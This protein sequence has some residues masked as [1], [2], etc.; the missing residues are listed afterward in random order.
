[1]Q[2]P[3]TPSP[4]ATTP[5]VGEERFLLVGRDRLAGS[6]TRLWATAREQLAEDP[7][8]VAEAH[9]CAA[10]MDAW[11]R[12]LRKEPADVLDLLPFEILANAIQRRSGVV[13]MQVLDQ[14]GD[15]VKIPRPPL[16]TSLV[17]T[18][19]QVEELFQI[20]GG[21]VETEVSLGF[22]QGHAG[23]GLYAWMTEYPDEGAI[24]LFDVPE[25]EEQP[26]L[27]AEKAP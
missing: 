10:R 25:V 1:M 22:G 2:P 18:G 8:K 4:F 6:L 5:H 23:V 3:N 26:D 24:A 7:A 13:M 15:K 9:D 21:D 27:L 17:L 11:C 12:A 19:R 16:A 20:V 14:P